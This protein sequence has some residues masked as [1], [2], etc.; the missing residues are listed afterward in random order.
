LAKHNILQAPSQF[1]MITYARRLKATE[2][3]N[4]AAPN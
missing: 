4:T 1:I 2:A 3:R